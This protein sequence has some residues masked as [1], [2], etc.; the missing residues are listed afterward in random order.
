MVGVVK[1]RVAP[2]PGFNDFRDHF[3][4]SLGSESATK[5]DQGVTRETS[6]AT[7]N[8]FWRYPENKR[9]QG[10]GP[11]GLALTIP[12]PGA[13]PAAPHFAPVRY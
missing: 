12:D 13:Q 8:H 3:G 2:I 10:E 1:S 9:F 5:D 11:H 6:G 7:W 4:E